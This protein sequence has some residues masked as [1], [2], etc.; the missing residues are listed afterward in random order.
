MTRT[1]ARVF[2]PLTVGGGAQRAGV[3]R[4]PA[5]GSGQG[6][7]QLGR[8][9][10]PSSTSPRGSPA[11]RRSSARIDVKRRPHT[12]LQEWEVDAVAGRTWP[13]GIEHAWA[14]E[15]AARGGRAA[16][17]EHGPGRDE[18]GLRPRAPRAR[19]A[20]TIL[21]IAPAA[22]A[23]SSTSPRGCG[24]PTPRSRL[25]S[26]TTGSTQCRKPRPT[27]APEDRGEAVSA[28]AVP[29]R[30]SLPIL[31]RSRRSSPA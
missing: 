12:S 7:G 18:G 16:P 23:R 21:V 13:T 26:S 15:V 2:A 27:C 19:G 11:P 10:D 8:R 17:H 6:L 9:E 29:L 30:V 4:A 31:R 5:R 14:R 22:S 24:S 3:R 20:V 28:R 25:R 1:A